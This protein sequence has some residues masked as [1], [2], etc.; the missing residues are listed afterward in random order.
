MKP[1]WLITLFLACLAPSSAW[2]Q[3]ALHAPE[4][5]VVDGIATTRA[6]PGAPYELPGKRIVFANWYYIQPGN[7]DWRDDAGNSVYVHGNSGLYEARILERRLRCSPPSSFIP[8]ATRRSPGA[9]QHLMFPTIWNGSRDDTTVHRAGFQPR[10][11]D[12]ALGARRRAARTPPFGN[13]DG[14]RSGPHPI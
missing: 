3:G 9:D 2:S 6:V 4:R 12:L 8:T 14:G 1:I 13:W 10:R 7:L 5:K 11:Q